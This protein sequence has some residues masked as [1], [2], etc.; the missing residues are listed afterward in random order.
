MRSEILLHAVVPA[1]I[2]K[3]VP[4]SFTKSTIFLLNKYG[5]P[6]LKKYV[7][8]DRLIK[9]LMQTIGGEDQEGRR[10]GAEKLILIATH[11]DTSSVEANEYVID[12]CLAYSRLDVAG[13]FMI[14]ID[15]QLPDFRAT[16]AKF[17]AHVGTTG[18]PSN[19]IFPFLSQH[20]QWE[21]LS[22]LPL[23]A[24]IYQLTSLTTRAGVI[25]SRVLS[26]LIDNLQPAPGMDDYYDTL[27]MFLATV[28]ADVSADIRH[29]KMLKQ[30]ETFPGIEPMAEDIYNSDDETEWM[31]KLSRIH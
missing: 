31:N 20:K 19:N 26:I 23:T 14:R 5:S 11:W 2:M 12:L 29:V 17:D 10:I 3:Q 25:D 16:Q 4:A 28:P 30:G 1:L 8:V 13:V 21:L 22:T 9:S 18:Y 15:H 6:E 24:R 7:V 27:L